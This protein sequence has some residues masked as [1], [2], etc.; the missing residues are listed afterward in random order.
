[1]ESQAVCEEE[2]FVKMRNNLG[3]N[4]VHYR[5]GVLCTTLSD[6]S[7][8][9]VPRENRV[10]IDCILRELHASNLAGHVGVRKLVALIKYRF[11]WPK[12]EVDAK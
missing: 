9:L 12:L 2:W 1:M 4:G 8:P 5:N 7:I 10:L 6:K 11:Y 3:N